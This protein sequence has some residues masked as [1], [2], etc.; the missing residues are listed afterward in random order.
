MSE[1]SKII[2]ISTPEKLQDIYLQTEIPEFVRSIADAPYWPYKYLAQI[3]IYIYGKY[4]DSD[5]KNL[6]PEEMLVSILKDLDFGYNIKIISPEIAHSQ[7]KLGLKSVIENGAIYFEHPIYPGMYISPS[8]YSNTIC[9]EKESVFLRLAATLGAKSVK[10]DS[11]NISKK[12]GVF[13]SKISAKEVAGQLGF[14]AS[15]DKNGSI[16]RNIYKEFHKPQFKTP[17]IPQE[18]S[19][20]IHYDSV[21]RTMAANRIEANASKDRINIEFSEDTTFG[22]KASGKLATRGFSVGGE[23]K[24]L[25]ESTWCFEVEY[26]DLYA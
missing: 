11:I 21:L 13:G 1:F 20:W 9:T 7:I 10:L 18:L 4:R 22:A 14:S 25:T 24:A 5:I 15:F 3:G 8:N 12:S 6:S 17:F 23:T 19:D 16:V 2:L 26:Y